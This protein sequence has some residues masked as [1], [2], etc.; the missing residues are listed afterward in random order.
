M[1]LKVISSAISLFGSIQYLNMP[2]V[3]K[4]NAEKKAG[5]SIFNCISLPL[6]NRN[7]F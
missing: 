5:K 6:K 3:E 1:A 4:G 2:N 7:E